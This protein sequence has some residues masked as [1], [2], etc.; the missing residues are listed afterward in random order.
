MCDFLRGR[1]VGNDTGRL[2]QDYETKI[3]RGSSGFQD[4]AFASSFS[5][6]GNAG[7]NAL[8]QKPLQAVPE[9]K[10]VV[11]F[12]IVC[13]MLAAITIVTLKMR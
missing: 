10:I 6:P 8:I 2:F 3:R 1:F 4:D 9:S 7:I 12:W 5:K 13:I 11:R